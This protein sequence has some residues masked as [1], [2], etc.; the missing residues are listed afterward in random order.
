MENTNGWIK[1]K[2]DIW[3]N[4][5]VGKFSSIVK[6][7]DGNFYWFVIPN[8]HISYTNILA[9]GWEKDLELCKKRVERYL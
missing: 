1:S 7:D 8:R 2:Y 4:I 5:N 9:D 3:Y 6:Y